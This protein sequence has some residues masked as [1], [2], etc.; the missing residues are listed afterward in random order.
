M[1]EGAGF[2]GAEDIDAAEVFDGREALDDNFVASKF[3][4]ARGKADGCDHWKGL[5]NDSYGKGY[6]EQNRVGPVGYVMQ[7]EGFGGQH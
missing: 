1:G 2:V 3:Y 4:G 6:G 7:A 5:R